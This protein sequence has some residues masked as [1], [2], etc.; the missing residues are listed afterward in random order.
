M[1]PEKVNSHRVSTNNVVST[2]QGLAADRSA[3][4]NRQRSNAC[5]GSRGA[6]CGGPDSTASL[7]NSR[8]LVG[9]IEHIFSLSRGRANI[10]GHG[11]HISVLGSELQLMHN[12]N[13]HIRGWEFSP[14]LTADGQRTLLDWT[15]SL[16]IQ[17]TLRYKSTSSKKNLIGCEINNFLCMTRVEKENF[18][19]SFCE[20]P[21]IF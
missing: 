5:C 1:P 2:R 20:D 10:S 18:R 11:D 19:A 8:G 12:L 13:L 14:S 4:G 9:D 3:P 15:S 17:P 7:I 16:I 6:F 21:S